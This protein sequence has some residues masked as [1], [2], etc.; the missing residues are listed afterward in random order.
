MLRAVIRLKYNK[1]L[2]LELCMQVL[3]F[4]L[5]GKFRRP[6]QEKPKVYD[7]LHAEIAEVG[8]VIS[9]R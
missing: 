2:S 5:F 6:E 1:Y 8:E 7:F 3:N 4:A 9:A